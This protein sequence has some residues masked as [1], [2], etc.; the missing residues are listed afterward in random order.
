MWPW[1]HAALGYLLYRVVLPSRGRPWPPSDGTAIALAVG[2]QFPDLI[3]KPLAWSFGLI[4]SG[5][6]LA[7]SLVLATIVC[8]LVVT[9]ARRSGQSKPA[10]AFAFGYYAHLLGDAL[11]PILQLDAEFLSFL[12][13]PLLPP[14]PYESD[15]SFLEH[16]LNLSPTPFTLFGLL[17]TVFAMGIWIYDGYPGLRWLGTESGTPVSND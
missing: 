9:I 14:P 1:G 13:W 4:P 3:D 10:W 15:S 11:L 5:R 8:L 16:I 12:A 17:L 6:S 2:T 7:H